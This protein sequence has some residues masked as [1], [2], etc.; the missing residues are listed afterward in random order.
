MNS[1]TSRGIR[2]R[3]I[4]LVAVAVLAL[5]A[6]PVFADFAEFELVYTPSVPRGIYR[7]HDVHSR[8]LRTGDYVCLEG[9]R[10]EAPEAIRQAA[11]DGVVPRSWVEGERLTKRVA[12]VAGDRIDY[13]RDDLGGHIKV[14]GVPLPMS[15]ALEHDSAGARLPRPSLPRL[16]RKGEVWLT[17][18]HERGFD[19]RYFG[20]VSVAALSCRG[21][22]WWRW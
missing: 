9:W 7:M 19:S 15:T 17:S 3:W 12:A 21:E 22:L 18:E 11:R 8:S 6:P 10:A 5:T 16:L 4:N 1:A 14:N 13:V 20:A 2:E